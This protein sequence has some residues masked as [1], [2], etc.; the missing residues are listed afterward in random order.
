V[1]KTS[2]PRG[3]NPDYNPGPPGWGLSIGP[4]TLFRKKRVTKPHDETRKLRPTA[5]CNTKEEE[6][7]E[8]L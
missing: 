5:G 8:D 4:T 2:L 7:E 6:E 3:R 1:G